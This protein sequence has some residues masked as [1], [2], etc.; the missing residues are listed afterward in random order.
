L[1]AARWPKSARALVTS[2]IRK[3]RDQGLSSNEA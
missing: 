1:V 3:R 2:S